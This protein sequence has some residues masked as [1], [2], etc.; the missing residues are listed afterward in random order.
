MKD[1]TQE[2]NDLL[3]EG[4]RVIK[5][6]KESSTAQS[7][8]VRFIYQVLEDLNKIFKLNTKERTAMDLI[9][10]YRDNI[11]LFIKLLSSLPEFDSKIF[12]LLFRSLS[13]LNQLYSGYSNLFHLSSRFYSN[14]ATIIR[15][16]NKENLRQLGLQI[17]L[18]CPLNNKYKVD[19]NS[20]EAKMIFTAL[21]TASKLPGAEAFPFFKF[22]R[23]KEVEQQ[24]N[25]NIDK[26][27]EQIRYSEIAQCMSRSQHTLMPHPKSPNP[28]AAQVSELGSDVENDLEFV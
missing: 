21:L 12:I 13:E 4:L 11:N 25:A 28:P 27:S 14:L 19:V 10:H 2:A 17:H 24:W 8:Q 7:D 6:A 23:T 15:A 18:L 9:G 3:E 1:L 5:E 22:L 20:I 26:L 16:P